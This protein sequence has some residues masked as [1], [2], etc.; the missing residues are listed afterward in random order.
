M[1]NGNGI[2]SAKYKILRPI[3]LHQV[4]TLTSRGDSRFRGIVEDRGAND[5][6]L[7][8]RL[9]H[10]ILPAYRSRGVKIIPTDIRRKFERA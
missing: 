6:L 10:Q 7:R 9:A 1:P 8:N 5:L 2:G 3:L 4:T